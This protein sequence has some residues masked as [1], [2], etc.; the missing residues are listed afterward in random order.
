MAPWISRA[1]LAATDAFD[2]RSRICLISSRTRRKASR[3]AATPCGRER[4]LR[5]FDC[6]KAPVPSRPSPD[7]ERTRGRRG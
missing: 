2:A 1:E 7:I 4:P 6:T 5:H 3:A